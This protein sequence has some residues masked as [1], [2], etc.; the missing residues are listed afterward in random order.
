[1]KFGVHLPQAGRRATGKG[2]L[3]AAQQAESLGFHSVWLFDH[4]FT[5]EQH[6]G[7]YPG[8]PDGIYRF[9]LDAPYLE[10]TTVLGALAATTERV[11][12]GTRVLLPVLRNPAIL[13]KQLAATD[14]IAGG[15]LMLGMGS[16]WMPEEYAA[17]GVPFDGRGKRLDEHVTLMRAIWA[18]KGEAFDGEYY[19]HVAGSFL[20]AA[21]RGTIPVLFGGASKAA[22]RRVAR[23][24]DG[25]AVTTPPVEPRGDDPAD[26]V[27]PMIRDLLDTLRRE[28]DAVG[29]DFDELTLLGEAPLDATPRH[30]DGLAELGIHHCDLMSM[31]RPARLAEL[32]DDFAH[33]IG[34]E[35]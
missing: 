32:V 31:S 25:W 13:G 23:L 34:T 9:P 10:C 24:G 12:F 17:A 26:T 20:P 35:I 21:P 29:R 3:A 11:I 27:L 18:G 4:L 30:L 16:G 15:R 2:I 14:E 6:T 1:M 7:R 19:A 22:L 8:T 28:C 33:R 5:P